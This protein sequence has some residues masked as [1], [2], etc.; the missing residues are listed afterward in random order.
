VWLRWHH[1]GSILDLLPTTEQARELRAEMGCPTTGFEKTAEQISDTGLS[2]R[3]GETRSSQAAFLASPF[4][5][6]PSGE[7]GHTKKR[8]LRNLVRINRRLRADISPA[9]KVLDSLRKIVA[10]VF[11]AKCWRQKD[12]NCRALARRRSNARIAT[13][14]SSPLLYAEQTKAGALLGAATTRR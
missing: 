4:K 6:Y 12:L 9:R 2:R 1:H 13:G 11:T 3:F 10:R 5:V 14:K 8:R 7:T